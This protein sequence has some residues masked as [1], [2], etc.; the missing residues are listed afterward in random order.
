MSHR[1]PYRADST[2]PAGAFMP[3]SGG[4][5][6]PAPRA[7]ADESGAHAAIDASLPDRARAARPDGP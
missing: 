6:P 5:S 3:C 2:I 7:N 4:D 1:H